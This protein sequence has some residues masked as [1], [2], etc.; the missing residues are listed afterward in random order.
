MPHVTV[1]WATADTTAI[2]RIRQKFGI[3]QGMTVN[4]ETETTVSDGDMPLLRETERRGFIRIRD[5]K[6]NNQ[7]RED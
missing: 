7:T 4:G 5:K 3:T 1:Y 6:T 2:A